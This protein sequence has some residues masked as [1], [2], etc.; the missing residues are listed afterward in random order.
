MKVVCQ[1]HLQ[2]VAAS[3]VVLAQLQKMGRRVGGLLSDWLNNL[4]TRY[5]IQSECLLRMLLHICGSRPKCLTNET[6]FE[7]FIG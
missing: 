2:I 7:T 5:R 1:T 4:Q 3:F 6:S